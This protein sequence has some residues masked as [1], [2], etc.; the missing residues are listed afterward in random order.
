MSKGTKAGKKAEAKANAAPKAKDDPAIRQAVEETPGWEFEGD[1][2]VNE[3]GSQVPPG[4]VAAVA[5][6]N[7]KPDPPSS[8]RPGKKN[9]RPAKR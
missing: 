3:R 2:V 1:T 7:E 5:V 8:K 9:E 4:H 6:E